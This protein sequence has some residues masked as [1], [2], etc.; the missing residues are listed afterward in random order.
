MDEM[1]MV[2]IIIPTGNCQICPISTWKLF[3]KKERK[4]DL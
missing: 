3:L 1:K 4:T 2:P